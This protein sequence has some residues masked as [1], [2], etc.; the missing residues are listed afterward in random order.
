MP[1]KHKTQA[2][3]EYLLTYGWALVL[4]VTLVGAVV[5]IIGTPT[6]ETVF[7]SSDPTKIM[8]KSGSLTDGT[9]EIKM[10]NTTGGKI[11]ITSFS[12]MGNDCE[13][14]GQTEEIVVAAGGEI[15]IICQNV[16]DEELSQPLAIT[17]EDYASLERTVIITATEP[18]ATDGR[19]DLL[20]GES[21]TA[22]SQCQ[23]GICE[24]SICCDSSCPAEC[25]TCASSGEGCAARLDGDST[26]CS[27]C[28][29]CQAGSCQAQTASGAAATLLG[30]EAGDQGCRYC[31]AGNCLVYEDSAQHNCS[32][33]NT[34]GSGGLCEAT[35]ACLKGQQQQHWDALGGLA[36][37]TKNAHTATTAHAA[38][39]MTA[40]SMAVLKNVAAVNQGSAKSRVKAGQ[41]CIQKPLGI[42]VDGPL[43][44]L[45]ATITTAAAACGRKSPQCK[46][47]QHTRSGLK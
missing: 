35:L 32:A 4:I 18:T 6:E 33:C 2:G 16:S 43:F 40:S 14:N 41:A 11:T 25:E 37:E 39:T 24:D 1:K 34:C 30:C 45:I 17:Y 28:F 7:Y 20:L 44:P 21:C 36:V 46:Q 3:L 9:A 27:A 10:Q 15:S 13:I 12:G 5:F 47:A 22:N 8:L 26:E 38:I 23:S 19:T 29:S 42:L 31:N